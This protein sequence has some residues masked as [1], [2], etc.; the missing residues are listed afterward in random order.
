MRSSN[1]VL[2]EETFAP[3]DWAGIST[4]LAPRRAGVMTMTGTVAKTGFL[5]LLCI[6][7]ALGSAHAVA[8]LTF[9]PNILVLGGCLGGF[10]LALIISFKPMTAPFLSPLYALLQGAF[11]GAISFLVA[12]KNPAGGAMVM[13]AV[14]LTFGIFVALLVGYGLGLIRLGGTAMKIVMV[15]TLGV[16]LTY[17][18][19]FLFGMF[20]LNIMGALH[21][22]GAVGIGFSIVVIILA[23][24]NLVLDFQFIEGGV[25]SGAPKHM[26]W[27]AG[28]GLL[29]T[30]V[31][32]Y[33]EILRL[34]SKLNRR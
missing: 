4:E 14:A 1:P 26:E 16:A 32:L 34:L 13:Q 2:R 12:G 33:L 25:K 21:G 7:A 5:L 6:A 10:V 30:L 8:K 31:W 20:G 17:L 9:N 3:A 19:S 23:S 18:A 15:G 22:S 29:V 24:L 28:F 27:Y 11:L